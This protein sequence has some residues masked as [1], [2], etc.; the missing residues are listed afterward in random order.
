MV[1]PGVGTRHAQTLERLGLSTLADMLYYFPRRYD[2]YTQLIPINRLAYG[3]RSPSSPPFKTS[4]AGLSAV[5]GLQ[6]VETV[7]SDGSGSLRVT[8]FNQPWIAKR[9]HKN[10]PVV[11]SGKVEQYLGRLV[12]NNPEVE[13]VDQQNLHTNRIVPVYP[14]TANITQKW[15]RRM[16]FQVVSYWAPRVSDPLPDDL[17]QAADLLLLLPLCKK[18]ISHPR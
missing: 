12:M 4:T 16:M 14:L 8:W 3:Q 13:A 15:L 5:V 17:R 18:H 2:D 1:L 11:L 6:I 9:L 10:M 7:V